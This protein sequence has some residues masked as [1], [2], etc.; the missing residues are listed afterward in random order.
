MP[1]YAK[2]MAGGLTWTADAGLSKTNG[3]WNDVAAAD[4]DKDGD[5]DFVV[6][7]H[8]LNSRFR[9]SVDKPVT[10]AVN[11]FDRN[12]TIEQIVSCYIGDKSY[13]MALR[14]DLIAQIPSLKK[15]FLK[16]DSY[17][18]KTLNEIFTTDELTGVKTLEVFEL[19]S[20]IL[21]NDG[22]GKFSFERLPVDAQFSAMYGILIKDI[23][24]DGNN[25]IIMGGN[26]FRTKP[27][28]GRYDASYGVVLKG[29]AKGNLTSLP[30]ME[31]GLLL[32]GEVRDFSNIKIAGADVLMVARNNAPLQFFKLKKK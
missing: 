14:H 7:N 27:E 25:D 13:P 23:D 9:A 15:K 29:D 26:L 16:Y 20:G 1:G 12:G 24:Q 3:W 6:A 31:S 2:Q 21:R 22:K 19:A 28:V 17:K 11:D 18:D 4:L 32:E 10:M 30:P 5:V 8:G